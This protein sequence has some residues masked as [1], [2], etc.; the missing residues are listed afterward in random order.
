MSTV[1]G[2]AQEIGGF[3][4]AHRQELFTYALSIV[5]TVPCAEDAVHEAVSRLLALRRI[6]RE[7]RPYAF[8]CVRNA[9]LD[10]LRSAAREQEKIEGYRIIFDEARLDTRHDA[11]LDLLDSLPARD[12]EIIVLKVFSGLTFREIAAVC[13]GRQGTVAASYWRSLRKLRERLPEENVL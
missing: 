8:R 6:P 7:L 13:G 2:I 4:A 10:F 11:A 5:G 1:D 12:R 3:Y 9:A